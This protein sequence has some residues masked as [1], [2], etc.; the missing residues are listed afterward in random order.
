MD[1]EKLPLVVTVECYEV[2]VILEHVY[3]LFA[4]FHAIDSVLDDT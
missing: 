3:G 4:G 2:W 1:F